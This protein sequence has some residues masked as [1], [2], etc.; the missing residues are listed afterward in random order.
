M[1]DERIIT[2]KSQLLDLLFAQLNSAKDWQMRTD[3]KH[4]D[5]YVALRD[6]FKRRDAITPKRL[7]EIVRPL[8]SKPDPNSPKVL[9]GQPLWYLS[10]V[11]MAEVYETYFS[12]RV[13]VDYYILWMLRFVEELTDW[14]NTELRIV[15]TETHLRFHYLPACPAVLPRFDVTVPISGSGFCGNLG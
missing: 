3:R 7:D 2:S 9:A 12:R 4:F 5:S 15:Q 13:G 6:A 11:V 8:D 1:S 14:D 10:Q